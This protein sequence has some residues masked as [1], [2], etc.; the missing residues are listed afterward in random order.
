[1][2]APGHICDATRAGFVRVRSYDE[3]VVIDVDGVLDERVARTIGTATQGAS[4][5]HT[6]RRVRIELG[7]VGGFTQ[8]GLRIFAALQSR[9]PPGAG[10]QITY[11]ASSASGQEALLAAYVMSR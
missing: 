3:V 10:H 7:H 2:A 1:M 4:E 9:F 8:D 5:G 11:H 6:R